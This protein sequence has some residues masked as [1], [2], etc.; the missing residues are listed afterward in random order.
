MTA[1]NT[2][3]ISVLMNASR[4]KIINSGTARASSMNEAR[5]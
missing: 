1:E 3:H 2:C 5:S 4:A